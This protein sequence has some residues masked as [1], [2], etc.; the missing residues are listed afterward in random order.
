MSK[1]FKKTII[2]I[3]SALM[4]FATGCGKDNDK[5]NNV[6]AEDVVLWGCP[7]TEKVLKDKPIEDYFNIMTEPEIQILMA[8]NEYENGQVIIS[9]KEDIPYYNASISDLAL[10]GGDAVI[11]KENIDVLV[12]KYL[13]VNITYQTNGA[14]KGYYPDAL[15]PM[16]AIDSYG[17]N[18]I[19]EDTNQAIYL[20]VQTSLEQPSG[21]YK[22]TLSIDFDTFIA[23]V[24]VIVTVMEI[25]VSEETHMKSCYLNGWNHQGDLYTGQGSKDMYNE[26][27]I[28]YRMMPSTILLENKHTDEDIERY[29]EKAYSY[30]QNPKCANIGIPYHTSTSTY[31]YSDKFDA[32]GNPLTKNVQTIDKGVFKKYLLA[33]LDKS[34]ETGMDMYAKSSLYNAIIDEPH[35]RGLYEEVLQGC[36]NFNTT[37]TE[38]KTFIIENKSAY[39]EK[40]KGEDYPVEDKEAFL[41]QL[42]ASLDEIPNIVTSKYVAAYADYD[43]DE[44]INAFCPDLDDCNSEGQRNLYE[45]S[46]KQTDKW[47]YWANGQFFPYPNV[48]IDSTNLFQQRLIGWMQG[49]YNVMGQLYWSVNYYSSW[50]SA[51]S[52]NVIIEDFFE[53]NAL[54]YNGKCIG[55]GYLFYPGGQYGLDEPICSLRI[56]A[57]RDGIEDFELIYALKEKYRNSF[58]SET[59]DPD[60]FV[61]SMNSVLYVG[62]KVTAD[63]ESFAQVRETLLKVSS[64][65]LSDSEMSIIGTTDNGDGTSTNKIFVKD[66]YK[67]YVNDELQ[68]NGT[69]YTTLTNSEGKIYSI[70]TE[71]KE[72][73]NVLDVYCVSEDGAKK[74]SYEQDMGGKVNVAEA[75]EFATSFKEH[76][77]FVTSLCTI[78]TELVEASDVNEKLSGKLVKVDVGGTTTSQ[79]IFKIENNLFND[80]NSTIKKIVIVLYNDT[81][82]DMSIKVSL[83]QQKL[84]Y[85]VVLA[86]TAI[87]AKELTAIELE[88]ASTN[89]GKYGKLERI[90]FD[91]GDSDNKTPESAKTFYL[92]QFTIYSK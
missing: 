84:E 15:V 13:V 37:I 46:E 89:W 1:K 42:I 53:G 83:K 57:L 92:K 54:R 6:K 38:I 47:W 73:S 27:M 90:F 69:P 79:Q 60:S 76:A 5:N 31:V 33:Y 25:A 9:A 82:T 91:L 65:A 43:G 11:P 8:K 51:N 10:E 7:S 14:P 64:I 28:E 17:E 56:E 20:R 77:P 44:Y 36:K 87:K 88:V 61:E 19:A 49:D 2:Y 3:L 18:K 72:N 78:S 12:A 22:G 67:L 30:M 55:E 70:T 24:P 86:D 41:E 52:K 45:I 81:D 62:T 32:K 34:L 35:A 4:I 23:S 29:V 75:E 26:A 66:G 58:D 40:V 59:V 68:A 50:D 39:V 74:Y 48:M 80:V 21:I 16:S 85:S 71:L 63:S